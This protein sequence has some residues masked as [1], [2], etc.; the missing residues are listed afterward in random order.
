MER[1]RQ[2]LILAPRT[3]GKTH[4][5]RHACGSRGTPVVDGDDVIGAAKLWPKAD[6]W[7]EKPDGY[8]WHVRH[9]ETLHTV[10]ADNRD[11]TI[12]FNTHLPALMQVWKSRSSAPKIVGVA[13][14]DEHYRLA[15]HRR[16]ADIDAGLERGAHEPH[17]TEEK[18]LD[19]VSRFR[20]RLVQY[21]IPVFESWRQM[22]SAT[23]LYIRRT[24][25]E[26]KS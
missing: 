22:A 25:T 12:V 26:L 7:W 2:Y 15:V 10:F 11:L 9:C 18:I 5:T 4:F 6:K 17:V 16:N 3:S 1:Q 20:A 8:S 24:F 14:P 19:E 21:S 13:L 23:G